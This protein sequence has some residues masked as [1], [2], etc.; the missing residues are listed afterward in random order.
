MAN[1]TEQMNGT[2]LAPAQPQPT[3]PLAPVVAGNRG[4]EL[5]TLDDMWRFAGLAFTSGLAPKG[6]SR[7]AC[8]VAI[9]MGAECGL[10]PMASMQNIA[11]VN[12]RPSIWG[13]AQMAIC[14]ASGAWNE[15]AH[16]EGWGGTGDEFHAYCQVARVGG[17]PHR[18]T[19]SVAEAKQAGLWGKPGPW[20]QYSKDMLMW[21]ARSRALRAKFSDALRGFVCVEEARDF[22]DV[23]AAASAPAEL[24]KPAQSRSQR[25]IAQAQAVA[26][27]SAVTPQAESAAAETHP[28][29]A[30]TASETAAGPAD[31][32]AKLDNEG[33]KKLAGKI[34]ALSGEARKRLLAEYNIGATAVVGGIHRLSGKD[35][36]SLSDEVASLS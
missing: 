30:E 14:R 12:G 20:Q 21:R 13:D 28:T 19:F 7:E 10:P 15:A 34:A 26:P 32:A 31:D 24:P 33:V 36:Q 27:E 17:K 11:V 23:E 4:L 5:R 9:Q 6:M 1:E 25:L 22:I 3:R 16:E 18:A 2:D 8:M 35:Q 29:Q